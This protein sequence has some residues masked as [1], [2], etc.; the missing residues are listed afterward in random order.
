MV[1]VPDEYVSRTGLAFVIDTNTV[2]DRS[3]EM[4]R[5]RQRHTDGWINL[6]RTDTVDTELSNA[7]DNKRD[8]LLDQSGQFVEHFGPLVLNHSRFDSSV[9]GVQEDEDRLALVFRVLFPGTDRQTARRN[10]IR[11]AMHVATGVRYG[12]TGLIT[13]DLGLLKRDEM[14]RMKFNNFRVLSPAAAVDLTDRQVAKHEEL[15]RRT[16]TKPSV[17]GDSEP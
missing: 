10:H 6:S 13:N 7:P 1:A 12:A 14:I 8:S 3:T 15:A 9:S 16:S 4:R 11:D 17:H 2:D 5:L